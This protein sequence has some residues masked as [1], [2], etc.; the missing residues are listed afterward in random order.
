MLSDFTIHVYIDSSEY[1]T[2]TRDML[3]NN[4]TSLF[5]DETIVIL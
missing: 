1:D 3:I 2:F 5:L 4:C